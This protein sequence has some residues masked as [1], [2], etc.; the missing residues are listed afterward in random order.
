MNPIAAFTQA[1]Q[2]WSMELV[3]AFG[4]AAQ[5]QRYLPAGRGAPGSTLRAA[6]DARALAQEAYDAYWQARHS[7]G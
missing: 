2:R 7:R 6:Y 3:S 4:V 5:T 1:D